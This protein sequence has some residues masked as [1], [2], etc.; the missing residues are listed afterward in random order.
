MRFIPPKN[1]LIKISFALAIISFYTYI[2]AVMDFV[3]GGEFLDLPNYYDYSTDTDNAE[4]TG[5]ESDFETGTNAVLGVDFSDNRVPQFTDF[6]A[7]P[8]VPRNDADNDDESGEDDYDNESDV[9]GAGS[10]NDS[11]YETGL[12][13]EDEV[14]SV[15][16]EG[17]GESSIPEVAPPTTTTQTASTMTP[18]ATSPPAETTAPNS[19]SGGNSG[20][21][22]G[23]TSGGNSNRPGVS[24]TFR[25]TSNGRIVEGEAFDILTRVVEAEIG[26][27][28]HREAIKA[29]VI[30][31]YTYIRRHNEAGNAPVLPI[32][33]EA[34]ER[35][36]RY[37]REVFGTA[38]FHNGELIQAAFSASSAG[39]TS[40]ARNVWGRD[41]PYLQSVRT[42]FDERHCPRWQYQRDFTASEIRDNVRR[43]TGIELTGAPSNW[44]RIVNHVDTVYVGTLSIGG[45]NS[46]T[47]NGVETPLTGRF[48]REQIM[49]FELRSASFTFTYNSST[50]TFTFTTNGF[51]HGVGLSQN[52]ANILATHHGYSHRDILLFYYRGVTIR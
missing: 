38:I 35:T 12:V 49:G 52:G 47:R 6:V 41:I 25:I 40:S 10:E 11:G 36:L 19:G 9:L 1:I 43:V 3:D 29:Q 2:F 39:W 15:G 26:G 13:G 22:G 51:G 34:T 50:D 30:A 8:T 21:S 37:A 17:D 16:V 31:A 32:R 46:F 7:A 20:S 23:N 24:Q 5:E 14:Q 33:P 28:F 42:S 27:N 45:Q 48:F 44:L 18:V 4:N